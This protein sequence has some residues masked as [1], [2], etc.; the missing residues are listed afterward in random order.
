MQYLRILLIVVLAFVVSGCFA[1]KQ[2]EEPVKPAWG[3]SEE[4]RLKSLEENFL[5]FKEGLRQQNDL[6]ESN[7]KDTTAQIEK[8][9]ERMTEMDS[10]LAE[11][12]ENQQKMMTMK[13]EQEIP[14]EEA[15]VTEEVVMGGNSSSEEKPWMVVPGEASAAAGAA[16]VDPAK[17]APKPVS[18]LSGDALYQEGVRLVMNDNPVKARG[19]LEQYLAQNPSSKLAPNALYWI[20]ETYYS[21]KSFAQSILKFKE[22]SRRFP[23]ATKVPDAMLKIGLA[24]DK[25]GDRENAVF[26]LRTL[27][28]DYPKSAPAKI[29]RERLRAIEG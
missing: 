17:A 6:I 15:V 27:I 28:E 16:Q 23:K 8:L 10:T 21:E 24:Y 14:A 12:K 11:L 2:P 19:L 9:Q 4:W 20:G 26:Y 5:H 29:G 25:L 3:G 13:V 1:A 22:V 7:H 18:S